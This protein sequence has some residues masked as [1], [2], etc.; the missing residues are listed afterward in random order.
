MRNE[1][2][3][4]PTLDLAASYAFTDRQGNFNRFQFGEGVIGQAALENE[5]IIFSDLV[6]QAPAG[7]YGAAEKIPANYNY[8]IIPISFEN[9]TIGVMM[10][11]AM[12]KFTDLQKC[13]VAQNI[14]NAAILFNAARSRE[15]VRELYLMS[16]RQQKELFVTVQQYPTY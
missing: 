8:M 13:F 11:G 7:N 10:I 14:D 2:E 5:I 1:Q 6:A 15:K 16:E 3:K 4:E 9:A 12:K